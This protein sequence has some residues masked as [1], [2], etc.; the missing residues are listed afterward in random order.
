M[1]LK[2]GVASAAV[3]VRSALLIVL[4]IDGWGPL[5]LLVPHGGQP[6]ALRRRLRRAWWAA[7]DADGGDPPA[8]RLLAALLRQPGSDLIPWPVGR[9]AALP[10]GPLYRHRL[11]GRPGDRHLWMRSWIQLAPQAPWLACADE[12]RLDRSLMDLS[13]AAVT[14]RQPRPSVAQAPSAADDLPIRPAAKHPQLLLSGAGEQRSPQ[15]PW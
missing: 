7:A 4:G 1:A 3:P 2:E 6:S 10:S 13:G 14:D 15:P 11:R 9:L 8:A 12:R 5:L